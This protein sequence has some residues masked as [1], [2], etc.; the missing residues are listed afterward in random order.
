[1]AKLNLEELKKVVHKANENNEIFLTES[2]YNR[3]RNHIEDGA[4]FAII[5]SD[6]HERSGR[7][8]KWREASH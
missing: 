1:M 4:A 6:R 7:E 2:S 3:I 8:N 5:T